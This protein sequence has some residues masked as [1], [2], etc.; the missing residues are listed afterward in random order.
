MI[1]AISSMLRII[2]DKKTINFLLGI[3]SVTMIL[4]MYFSNFYLDENHITIHRDNYQI[5]YIFEAITFMQ[6]I[7]VILVIY[8]SLMMIKVEKLTHL[9]LQ[10]LSR[11]K[12]TISK[13]VSSIVVI[14]IH[15]SIIM[16]IFTIIALFLTPFEIEILSTLS[17]YGQMILF[18]IYYSSLSLFLSSFTTSKY[19]GVGL[20]IFFLVGNTFAPYF[21]KISDISALESISSLI[22]NVIVFNESL[23]SLFIGG[24]LYVLMISTVIFFATIFRFGKSDII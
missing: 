7:T 12:Y 4:L 18:G 19:V 16:G 22:T 3:I 11:I 15:T 13:T 24:S 20:F 1:Y 10:R 9:Y 17:L 8:L 21:E 6:I 14:S 2:L 23:E 5:E